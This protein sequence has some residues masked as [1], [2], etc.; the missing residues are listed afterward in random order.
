MRKMVKGN[1][2]LKVVEHIILRNMW[3]YYV[4][5]NDPD[6]HQA[7]PDIVYALVMGDHD[8]I[9]AVSMSEI[10]PYI[11]SRTTELSTI[12][13]A[14]GYEWADEMKGRLPNV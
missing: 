6:Q 8:E 3:E 11:F 10:K 12:F 2:K 1:L 14:T 13:P 7:D 5:A 4:L 9:G